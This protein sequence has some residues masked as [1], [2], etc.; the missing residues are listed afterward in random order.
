MPRGC[1]IVIAVVVLLFLGLPL[2][3]NFLVDL[4]WFDSQHLSSVYTTRISVQGLVFIAA[5]LIAAAF[6]LINLL[7]ARR[8]SVPRQL[9]P[10][11][12]LTISSGQF[13][14][15]VWAV[16]ILFGIFFGVGAAGNWENVLRFFN[17]SS[18][19]TTDPIFNQD[20]GFYIFSLPFY[21]AL[22]GWFSA[23]LLI[24]IIAVAAVY[25]SGA[26]LVGQEG[27]SVRIPAFLG[28]REPVVIPIAMPAAMRV[29]LSI[30]A[31]IYLATF[32]IGYRLDQYKLLASD[33]SILYGA[34]YTD[35]NA[36]L[37]GYW[38]LLVVATLSALILL[39][40]IRFRTITL[41]GG[42]IALWIL[43]AILVGGVY[44]GVI[45]NFVVKPSQ[46]SLE[47]PYITNNITATRQAFNLNNITVRQDN[48]QPL[49]Q[50]DV[51]SSPQT[52]SNV[53]LWDYLPLLS[54]YNQRQSLETY[55]DF[56][57]VDIDRYT[58]AGNYRQVMIAPRELNTAGLP[59]GAQTWVNQ[60]LQYTHGYG[61]TMSPV[62]E[63]GPG[64]Q[65]NYFVSGVPPTSTVGVNISRPEIYFGER[66]S[67]YIIVNTGQQ[68]FDYRSSSTGDVRTTYTGT[69]GVVLDSF[70]KKAL[71][72]YHFGDGNIL[73]SNYISDQ[74]R[75]IFNRN[76]QERINKVAPFLLLDLDPYITIVNGKLYWVQDAYT[77]SDDY[78][79]SRPLDNPSPNPNQNIN[80]QP[81]QFNYIRNSVKV[82]IDAYNGDMT[83]YAFDPSD[84]ILQTYSKI[85]PAL[86]TPA[87]QMPAEMRAH[88]RYP[89]YIFNV[90]AEQYRT[91]HMTD[92]TEFYNQADAWDIPA[93]DQNSTDQLT[94]KL[95]GQPA[96]RMQAYY[97]IM[98]IP[99][100]P[101]EEFLLMLPF[102]PKAKNNMV[103]WMAAKSDG[104]DYGKIEV[105]TFPR[106]LQIDGPEQVTARIN[107]DPEISQLRTLLG[108]QGSSVILGNLLVIPTGNSLLY[109]QPFYVQAAQNAQPSLVRVIVASGTQVAD[110]TN[111][112][113]ALTSLFTKIA[114]AGG[115]GLGS[116]V[117]VGGNT[118]GT[119][120]AGTPVAQPTIPLATP[121]PQGT[122]GVNPDANLSTDQLIAATQG[123][124][125][126]AQAAL[127][128]TPP[129]WVTY[130]NEQ[131]ALKADLDLLTTRLATAITP[132]PL[133][134]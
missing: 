121:L 102:K 66:Q 76:I 8:T 46:I 19:G 95:N 63:I 85:F 106:Q 117:A 6:L 129:D 24:T 127:A 81:D 91:Y 36:K 56:T 50:Q 130:G 52:I 39:L 67:D 62:N 35:I 61:T 108:Q 11:Q 22:R 83:F 23:L 69:A 100:E 17:A 60:V 15:L 110:A 93:V 20:T 40:N 80:D 114:Q 48:V 96:G 99:G 5:T 12:E 45:E 68:E 70:W 4:L 1:L 43:A 7:I 90:Q 2:L 33:H 30:L 128:K 126:A 37:P 38:I 28:G 47:A 123:H 89:E 57:D 104:T 125:Q 27:T 3:F 111:L 86:F 105:I 26:R 94:S 49:T 55:Y 65:P 29:H 116:G 71:F 13:R 58:V 119:P 59:S 97:T 113:G 112:Q 107:Q 78:P 103:A 115:N 51:I 16:A 132:T 75:I 9:F 87:S 21:D 84:P 18:F 53:R 82:V 131:A 54:T 44:P 25:I 64:G 31:A 134:E 34:D 120:T 32:A 118:T 109:V 10:G 74:S 124:Y 92:P 41:L 73:L 72:A 79:Y 133:P 122:P 101:N 77:Y 98:R 14:G 42:A 88:I